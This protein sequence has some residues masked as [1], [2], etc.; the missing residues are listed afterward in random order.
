M[1]RV[2]KLCDLILTDGDPLSVE[3]LPEPMCYLPYTGHV[4]LV[5]NFLITFLKCF[6]QRLMQRKNV[7]SEHLPRKYSREF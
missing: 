7:L 2:A 1:L 6:S 4:Q 5:N 3:T